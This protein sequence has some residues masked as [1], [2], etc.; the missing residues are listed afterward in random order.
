MLFAQGMS[1]SV[2]PSYDGCQYQ[3]C[4]DCSA[5]RFKSLDWI[6]RDLRWRQQRQHSS[7]V[8]AAAIVLMAL[9]LAALW[10]THYCGFHDMK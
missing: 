6:E 10:S 7:P 8:T 2:Y 9:T 4:F 3:V 1:G 5:H